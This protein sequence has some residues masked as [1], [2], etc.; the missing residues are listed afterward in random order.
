MWDERLTVDKLDSLTE[1][2][3]LGFSI[4]LKLLHDLGKSIAAN[5]F[6]AQNPFK[7]ARSV[8]AFDQSHPKRP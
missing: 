7:E 8:A 3:F 5:S 2:G 1:F 4:E 6:A